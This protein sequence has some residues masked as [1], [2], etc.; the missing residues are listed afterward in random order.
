MTRIPPHSLDLLSKD[1][2]KTLAVKSAMTEAKENCD[3]VKID[4]IDSSRLEVADSE[5]LECIWTPSTW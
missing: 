1:H 4:H 3:F 2:V 5:V